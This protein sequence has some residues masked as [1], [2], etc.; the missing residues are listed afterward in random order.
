MTFL[1]KAIA[2][3]AK[4][5]GPSAGT[6]AGSVNAADLAKSIGVPMLI[7]GILLALPFASAVPAGPFVLVAVL[8]LVRRLPHEAVP[9]ED[10]PG[11][12]D[13]LEPFFPSPS[14]SAAAPSGP[15]VAAPSSGSA[16]PPPAP[17]PTSTSSAGGESINIQFPN[18]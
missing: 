6:K 12:S 5:F 16:S 4:F 9:G 15:T 10:H 7:Y 11:L 18:S 8:D 17:A 1:I 14:P 2:F 13:P 3:L